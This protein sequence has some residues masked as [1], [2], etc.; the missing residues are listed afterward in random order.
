MSLFGAGNLE[1]MSSF[2]GQLYHG[3]QNGL[4]I[5]SY[6]AR[7]GVQMRGAGD[8]YFAEGDGVC[9][10]RTCQYMTQVDI[11]EFLHKDLTE[12][13]C[14]APGCKAKFKQ[15]IDSE[16]HYNSK[17]RHSCQECKKNLPSAH[18]LDLHIAET[19]DTYFSVSV[20]SLILCSTWLNFC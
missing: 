13:S 9:A 3:G 14:Q 11:E 12:F 19:H 10:M 6:I 5:W 18:L 4:D 20:D 17:H 15:L 16:T 7:L 2:G 8:D 1:S